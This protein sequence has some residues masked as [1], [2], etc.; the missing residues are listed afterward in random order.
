[1]T[2]R[3]R[4]K[5]AVATAAAE[6]RGNAA[7]A[8]APATGTGEDRDFGELVWATQAT[9]TLGERP[10]SKRRKRRIRWRLVS[11]AAHAGEGHPPR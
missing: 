11:A 3:R 2:R 4:G 8:G 6:T 7:A 9:K 1:M 5:L 10:R